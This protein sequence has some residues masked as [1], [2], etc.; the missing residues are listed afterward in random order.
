LNNIKNWH[1]ALGIPAM[2]TAFGFGGDSEAYSFKIGEK[3]CTFH[4]AEMAP[5]CG[6][7]GINYS[8]QVFIHTELSPH[9]WSITWT[10]F[11]KPTFTGCAFFVPQYGLMVIQAGNTAHGWE[12]GQLHGTL[13]PGTPPDP[14]YCFPEIG[15]AGIAIV[16]SIRIPAL[17]EKWL[18]ENCDLEE[19]AEELQGILAEEEAEENADE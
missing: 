5:P 8:R 18:Q 19:V 10:T 11:R 9:C 7:Y 17:Y 12:P 3:M 1:T 2:D 13:L 4:R 15:Q 6:V 16:T 14:K